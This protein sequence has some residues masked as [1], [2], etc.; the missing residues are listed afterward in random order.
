MESYALRLRKKIPETNPIVIGISF[1]GMLVTEMAKSDKNIKAIII[2]SNKTKKEFPKFL[3]L[4]RYFP[5]YKWLPS[6]LFRKMI[7]VFKSILGAKGN[8][9]KRL[10][11]QVLIHTNIKFV[12]WAIGSILDWQNKN[13]PENLIHIH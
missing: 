10:L 11:K 13:V 9:P 4:G 5:L 1:G 7:L 8:D 3:R 6:N 2:S 12:K